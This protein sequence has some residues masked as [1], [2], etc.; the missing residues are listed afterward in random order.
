MNE[1]NG[2]GKWE[3][4]AFTISILSFILSIASLIGTFAFST[5][6]LNAANQANSMTEKSLELQN[7]ISN[8]TPIIVANPEYGRPLDE[9]GYFSNLTANF[10]TV[11]RGW[12]NGSLTVITPHYGD[13]T[14]EIINFTLNDYYDMLIPEKANLTTVTSTLEYNYSKHVNPVISGLNQFTFSINL[15]AMLY[16]NPQK[17]PSTS[18]SYSIFPVGVLFLEVKLF[19]AQAKI[20]YKQAFTSI[21]FVT[22]K[23]L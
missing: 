4:R 6:S 8:S 23:I 13:V 20:T 7:M 22:I 3:K 17:V 10:P 15:Q 19:D 21:I 11:S 9:D 16:P 18:S 5:Y 1:K 14:I 2:P 12:L